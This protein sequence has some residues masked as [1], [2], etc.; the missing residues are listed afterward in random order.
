MLDLGDLSRALA[1]SRGWATAVRSMKPINAAI[2]RDE[3]QL[4]SQRKPFRPLPPIASIAGSPLLR[5]LAVIQIRHA[6]ASWTP[7]DNGSL[8]LLAQYAPNLTS[9]WCKLT[10]TPNKPL[11]FPTKLQSLNL[12]LF[13]RYPMQRSTA[14]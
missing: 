7:L 13:R 6:N 12:Q 14:C 5:H 4:H 3:W 11:L 2:E 8:G 9:L 1:V 10:L